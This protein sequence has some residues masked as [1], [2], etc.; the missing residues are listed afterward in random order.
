MKNDARLGIEGLNGEDHILPSKDVEWAKKMQ[1]DGSI[2]RRNAK[3][4]KDLL[5]VGDVLL[6]VPLLDETNGVFLNCS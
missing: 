3:R 1:S 4:V 5:S 6:D 2:S